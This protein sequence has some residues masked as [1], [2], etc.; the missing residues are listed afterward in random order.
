MY[1][2]E[3]MLQFARYS[4][5]GMALPFLFGEAHG[6]L[7]SNR[8]EPYFTTRG[9]VL[10]PSDLVDVDWP[11]IAYAAGLST[12]GV[13]GGPADVVEFIKGEHGARFIERCQD[14]KLDVEYQLHATRDLL[15]RE[16]FEKDPAMFRMDD[17][18]NRVP[19]ANCC[20]S[21][22]DGLAVIGENAVKFAEL[23]RPTT[24][25][26]FYWPDDAA[27]TCKCSQC[28]IYS[29]SEQAVIVENAILAAL[30][31]IDMQANLS[32]LAYV[33][34]LS[35][36]QNVQPEPGL[37]LEFAPIERSWAD[38]LS[39]KSVIGR[40]GAGRRPT[41]HGQT[42]EL[43]DGNLERF[44]RETAQ[45]LEYWLDASLHSK[46]NRP[47]VQVPWNADVLRDDLKTYAQRGVRHVTSFAAWIDGDYVRRFGAP[48]FVSKYGAEL[49]AFNP[50]E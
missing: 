21:S 43:L 36:P 2:R 16:L 25:R 46:W 33:G 5:A 6:R 35:P 11:Q 17:D 28:R 34:T 20:P 7:R 49:R 4:T 39:A 9:V 22:G 29:D 19:D 41:S 32:H 37:F 38:P 40:T 13:H 24:H 50:Q 12:I 15:P 14:L 26:Y 31:K 48:E 23:L 44:P 42:L 1:R 8:Q 10:L 3:W 27:P 18:G 47:S 30:R 45:I